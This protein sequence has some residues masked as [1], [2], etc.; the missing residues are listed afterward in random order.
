LPA[1]ARSFNGFYTQN[2][3]FVLY[4]QTRILLAF[5]FLLIVVL[6][7]SGMLLRWYLRRRRRVRA[8]AT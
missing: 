7:A 5:A 3:I 8:T 4:S 2:G 1:I 6:V